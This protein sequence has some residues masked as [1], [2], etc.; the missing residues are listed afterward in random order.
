[1]NI[2][3]KIKQ[4]T[5]HF[6]DNLNIDEI[7]KISNLIKKHKQDNIYTI[8]IGKNIPLSIYLSDVLK[9]ISYTSFNLQSN[10]L[11]HGDLGCIRKN[12][13]VIIFSNSGNTS[14][15]VHI[16]PLIKNGFTILISCNG[17][18]KLKFLCDKSLILPKI[19]END[20]KFNLIPTTSF[21]N[22][23]IMLHHLIYYIL[24]NDDITLEEYN[25]NHPKGQ[26]GILSK[27]V[28]DLMV[29]VKNICISYPT[30]S[31]QRVIIN[32]L[33]R[34]EGYCCIMDNNIMV[35]IITDYNIRKAMMDK[36]NIY[37]L[38]ASQIMTRKYYFIT[39]L[40]TS[41]QNIIPIKYL[42]IPV[43]NSKKKLLGIIKN[44]K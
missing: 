1:M 35:G 5:T 10:N 3:E 8:G 38:I 36:Q 12:D 30:D 9:S 33:S 15:L 42:Y 31:L 11:T 22:F 44:I 13:L 29:P 28:K 41:Y 43:V 6:I 20:G 16:V 21:T 17:E 2:S 34:G 18:G 19:P 26:I 39:D 4:N 25:C 37:Q 23:S 7:K 24:S 32:M 27:K 14:E 40:E